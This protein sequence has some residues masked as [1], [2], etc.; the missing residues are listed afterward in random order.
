VPAEQ[1]KKQKK[2]GNERPNTTRAE[3]KK[4]QSNNTNLQMKNGRQ[5]QHKKTETLI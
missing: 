1:N 4:T 3:Q 2:T 5:C